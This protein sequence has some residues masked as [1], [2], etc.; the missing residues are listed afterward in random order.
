MNQSVSSK[1]NIAVPQ[2]PAEGSF[3]LGYRPELDGIRGIAILL[4]FVHHLYPPLMPGGFLGVDLF[5]V[6]SGFLITSLLLSEWQKSDAIDLKA[7][8]IR[9]LFRLMPAV[10]FLI[11]VLFAYAA[12]LEPN[13]EN[14]D[15]AYGG[16]FLTLSYVSNWIYALDLASAG[17][18]LGVTWSLA[19]EEQFY[20]I[21]PVLLIIAL[22]N[23]VDLRR[24][25][26]VVISVII[27]V[28][29]ERKFLADG[30][31]TVQR[32]YYGSD[33]RAD[34]LLM[35]CGSAILLLLYYERLK[36]YK[37]FFSIGAV[38]SLLFIAALLPRI[39]WNSPFLYQ[40]GYTLVA[41]AFAVMII[42]IVINKPRM[43]NGLLGV[44]PLV[45]IG[46]ISYGLY[47]WHWAVKFVV[48]DGRPEG[49]A[50][51]IFLAFTLSF[52]F[53][54]FSYFVVEKPFLALKEM[55]RG[56]KAHAEA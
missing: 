6:L 25:L 21:L 38:I 2:P 5:F 42:T 28:I 19:I 48:Y 15:S 7:F 47:L 4:V 1:S 27:L 3:V 49:S 8:Y 50:F 41:M 18:H 10:I 55:F 53:S 9:R 56:K 20:L 51:E 17:N 30:G 34:A 13:P 44:R 23:R 26:A 11:L 31:A 40:G 45:W 35:G 16:I 36:R 14:R 37:I 22:R 39:A 12:F 33:T 54:I 43:V 46:K 29:A 52:A 24:Q 32:L